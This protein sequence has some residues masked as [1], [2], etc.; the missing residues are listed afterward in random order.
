MYFCFFIHGKCVNL[1]FLLDRRYI[2]L[3][4]LR[5]QSRYF[6]KLFYFLRN[7]SETVDQFFCHIFHLFSVLDCSDPFINIQFLIFIRNIRS[8]N[9]CIHI[10][11]HRRCKCLLFFHL[12]FQLLHRLVQHLTVKV[13]SDCFHMSMLF[14]S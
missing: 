10:Q 6:Q 5:L 8:R 4:C 14:C 3:M 13:I 2:Q 1:A 12:A 7:I 9:K 11:I